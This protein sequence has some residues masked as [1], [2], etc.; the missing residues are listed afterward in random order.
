MRGVVR[1][2]AGLSPL[3]SGSRSE[4]PS[5]AERRS[6]TERT[7]RRGFIR[8]RTEVSLKLIPSYMYPLYGVAHGWLCLLVRAFT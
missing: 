4:A 8:T 2:I 5:G 6:G 3:A 1:M 7:E